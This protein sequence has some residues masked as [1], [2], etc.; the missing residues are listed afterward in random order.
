M[1]LPDDIAALLT[2]GHGVIT[3]AAAEHVGVSPERLERLVRHGRL[4]RLRRGVY[5][6]SV[7]LAPWT[8]YEREVRAALLICREESWATRWAGVVAHG[9]PHLGPPPSLIHL[10]RDKAPGVRPASHG[11]TRTLVATLPVSARTVAGGMRTCVAER[12]AL[13]LARHASFVEAL[14]VT[15]AVLYRGLTTPA[16]LVAEAERHAPWPGGRRAGRVSGHAD[17]RAESPL[18]TLGRSACIEFDLPVPLSNVW[19]GDG[20][21]EYRVD[22]LWP[23]HWLIGEGDGLNKYED[24]GAI[25]AEKERQWRLEQLGFTVV[26]Y[27]WRLAYSRRAVLAAR[28]AERLERTGIPSGSARWWLTAD[29]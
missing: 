10:V 29:R 20:Y 8:A 3:V 6:A 25:E 4:T 16:D 13:D 28:F 27:G 17:P 14:V 2:Q 19:V 22:H 1:D 5:G 21:P 9:L 26:R 24:R 7:N 23:D 12:V 18:E 11:R 15:D